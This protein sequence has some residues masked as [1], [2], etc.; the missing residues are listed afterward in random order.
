MEVQQDPSCRE[1]E[2]NSKRLV[3]GTRG[4]RKRACT[5]V[6]LLSTLFCLV[7][8]RLPGFSSGLFSESHPLTLASSLLDLRDINSKTSVLI[9]SLFKHSPLTVLLLKMFLG[10]VLVRWTSD[11]LTS[12]TR[13]QVINPGSFFHSINSKLKDNCS[14]RLRPHSS[15][16]LE[17]SETVV[18]HQINSEVMIPQF[19]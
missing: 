5:D 10:L 13:T 14:R 16:R 12:S 3:Q 18:D 6:D 7:I 11:L 8:L 4:T 19:S 17:K 15:C 2:K 1:Q 9:R